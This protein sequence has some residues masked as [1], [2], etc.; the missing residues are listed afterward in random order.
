[1]GSDQQIGRQTQYFAKESIDFIQSLGK[2]ADNHYRIQIQKWGEEPQIVEC[3]IED[4]FDEQANLKRG[5][6]WKDVLFYGQIPNITIGMLAWF[7]NSTWLGFNTRNIAALTSSVTVRRCDNVLN[8][9]DEFNNITPIPFVFDKY[10][11]LNSTTI[12]KASQPVSL[13]NGYKNAWVQYNEYTATMRTNDRFIINGV[14]WSVRGIDKVSRAHT[15]DRD[16]VRLMAFV[17]MRTEERDGD[18]LVNDIADADA[19]IWQVASSTSAVNGAVGSTGATPTTL[20]LNGE[21]ITDYSVIYS[22]SDETIVTVGADGSYELLAEGEATITCAF[23][24][25]PNV[26]LEIPVTVSATATDKYEVIFDPIEAQIPQYEYKV[27]SA[28]LYK[29]GVPTDTELTFNVGG[30]PKTFFALTDETAESIT[31]WCNAPY[32][33]NKLTVTA[34]AEVD[35]ITYESDITLSLVSAF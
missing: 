10:T 31:L 17:L 4:S 20:L 7:E 11:V 9:K 30:I 19:H 32:T 6:D 12:E 26:K 33:K 21:V 15:E 5:D 1:M 2:Y 8:F 29:N 13:V 35:G 22:S 24:K 25:N 16:S 27:V 3:R 18:D 23:E 28:H 14:A 34:K